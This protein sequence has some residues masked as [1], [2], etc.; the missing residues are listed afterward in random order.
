MFAEVFQFLRVT[1]DVAPTGAGPQTAIGALAYDSAATT[2]GLF[3]LALGRED[4]PRP[5]PTA[6]PAPPPVQ[7]PRGLRVVKDTAPL[8]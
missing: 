8:L 5:G 3:R 2:E 7:L 1:G 4:L 6:S